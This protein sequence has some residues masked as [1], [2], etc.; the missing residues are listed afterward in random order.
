MPYGNRKRELMDL[1]DINGFHPDP[2]EFNGFL[3]DL[4]AS[5]T[6]EG[7]AIKGDYTYYYWDPQERHMVAG[8]GA[9]LESDVASGSPTQLV[10]GAIIDYAFDDEGDLA[11]RIM[12]A[13]EDGS[14]MSSGLIVP[15]STYESQ[16]E[17]EEDV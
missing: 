6:D 10:L 3:D 7:Y 13:I 1:L 2:W 16:E 12:S 15:P 9:V 4:V 14:A 8:D 17:F 5:V 11:D